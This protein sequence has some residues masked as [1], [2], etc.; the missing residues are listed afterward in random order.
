MR[1]FTVDDAAH[2]LG[3]TAYYVLLNIP[4]QTAL[5]LA[6]AVMLHRGGRGIGFFRA[7]FVAPYL[8]TPVAMAVIWYW[9]W[10]PASAS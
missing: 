4:L 10:T 3:V 7:V 8:S 9:C 2:S 1:I 6:L 5:A